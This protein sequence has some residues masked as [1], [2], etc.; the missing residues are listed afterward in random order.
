MIITLVPREKNRKVACVLNG[1]EMLSTK[2]NYKQKHAFSHI[3]H[4]AVDNNLSEE[5]TE[6]L[7]C[8][9]KLF[10]AHPTPT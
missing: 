10:T 1:T 2:G 7:T 8:E 3:I 6:T 4:K 9:M 5:K